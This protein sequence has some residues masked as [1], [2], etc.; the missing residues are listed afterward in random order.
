MFSKFFRKIKSR[1]RKSDEKDESH[2][3]EKVCKKSRIRK[4]DES[5]EKAKHESEAN[6]KQ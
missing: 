5:D 1:I 4:S 6:M 3:T 2:N